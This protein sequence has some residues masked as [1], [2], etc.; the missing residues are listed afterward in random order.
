V[1]RKLVIGI[2][3]A[4]LLIVA[5]KKGDDYLSAR[6]HAETLRERV[7]MMLEGLRRG[8]ADSYQV[9]VCQWYDGSSACSGSVEIFKAAA[10]RFDRW[11]QSNGLAKPGSVEVGEAVVE[12]EPDLMMGPQGRVWAVVD[13]RRLTFV[14]RPRVELTIEP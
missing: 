5:V 12:G 4:A 1:T 13:G 11:V 10:D 7:S 3:L 6:G 9:A 2:G 8:T 14:V